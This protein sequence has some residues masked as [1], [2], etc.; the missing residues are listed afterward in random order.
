MKNE[1]AFRPNRCA[2]TS[3]EQQVTLSGALRKKNAADEAGTNTVLT[4][5]RRVFASLERSTRRKGTPFSTS[6]TSSRNRIGLYLK[7]L[8]IEGPW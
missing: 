8:E 5:H 2:T 7:E 3:V 6:P 1:P 4:S